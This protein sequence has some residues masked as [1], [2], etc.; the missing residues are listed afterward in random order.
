LIESARTSRVNHARPQMSRPSHGKEVRKQPQGDLRDPRYTGG[1]GGLEETMMTAL[2]GLTA[3]QP[4]D[5]PYPAG[6]NAKGCSTVPHLLPRW[7]PTYQMN[8]S[9]IIMSC[10]YTGP[11]EPKSIQGWS[12]VDFDW[13]N[14]KGRGTAD[15]WAKHQPMDCEELMV[16]QV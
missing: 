11:T 3:A 7:S 8:R 16:K 6:C 9:S 12:F 4:P 14:W 1:K 2:L 15:G 13:S 10:N 5:W